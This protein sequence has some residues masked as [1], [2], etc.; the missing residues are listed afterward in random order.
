MKRAV[1]CLLFAVSLPLKGELIEVS[2]EAGDGG[3]V[4]ADFYDAD[5]KVAVVLAHGKVFDKNSWKKVADSLERAKISALAINFRGYGLSVGIKEELYHDITGAVDFLKRKNVDCIAVVGASMGAIALKDYLASIPGKIDAAIFLSPP[6]SEAIT[7][8]I[9]KLIVFGKD[10]PI[11]SRIESV[12]ENSSS[13]KEVLKL[14]TDKHAQHIFKTSQ[15]DNIVK[16]IINFVKTI[17][18]R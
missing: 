15:G 13:P 2:F 14:N 1:F 3:F 6:F 5:S 11:A 8:E 12:Y 16:S 7:T 4:E 9:P 18:S 17:C 10:E